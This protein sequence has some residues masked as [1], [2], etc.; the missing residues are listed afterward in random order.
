M[1][2]TAAIRSTSQGALSTVVNANQATTS[3]AR[4]LDANGNPIDDDA[5]AATGQDSTKATTLTKIPKTEAEKNAAAAKA[6]KAATTVP[7]TETTPKA[8]IG[9]GDI[10]AADAN[11]KA[12]DAKAAADQANASTTK[13]SSW[14]NAGAQGNPSFNSSNDRVLAMGGESLQ[15]QFD[16]SKPENL[17]GGFKS[18]EPA[19]GGGNSS[20]QQASLGGGFGGGPGGF[21]GIG[22]ANAG[23]GGMNL[24]S[25]NVTINSNNGSGN[26]DSFNNVI[27][28]GGSFGGGAP[29][30]PDISSLPIAENNDSR[31]REIAKVSEDDQ[32]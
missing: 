14:T 16:I 5:L 20:D 23:P 26:L 18:P 29:V 25:G 24:N 32:P 6:A 2:L 21:G 17:I 9:A 31:I 28:N 12:A 22:G 30:I 15:K 8:P 1:S 11:A 7:A 13:D 19:S 3:T 4:K 10:I 27:G